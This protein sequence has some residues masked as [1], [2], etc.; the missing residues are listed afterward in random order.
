[1]RYDFDEVIQRKHT[2]SSKWDNVG[3]RV[4]NPD[5]LPLWVADTDFRCPQPVVD[6][7]IQRAQHPIYG[8]PYVTPDFYD[9]TVNWIEKRHGWRL[10]PEWI[11]FTTGIVPVF[12]TMIQA[13]TE[14]GDEVIVQRPVYHPI[15]H[16]IEDNGRAISINRL[17]YKNGRYSV[18]FE[19]LECRVKN[20]KAKLMLMCSPHNPAGGRVWTGTELRRIMEITLANDVLVVLDEIHSDLVLFGN[21]HIP[22]ASLDARYLQHTVTC[23]APSKT[24]NIAGLRG[25][26]IV[27]PNAE[28]RARFERQIK[29][30]RSVAQ[31]VFA[32][33]AYV[34]AYEHGEEYLAQLLP[35][36]EDNY[37][38]LDSYLKENMPRIKLVWPESTFLAWLDC[39][40]TGLSGNDLADFFIH[41]SLVAISRGDSFGPE[42]GDF[43]RI[44]VGCPRATLKKA[45]DNV[46]AEYD[47]RW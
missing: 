15:N 35:Y 47:K 17:I 24:F 28:L 43:A 6:A 18:D 36:L 22:A 14:P 34:A 16:A 23:Y 21:R 41:E 7:V 13:F 11:V 10:K 25:S 19:D 42:G 26:G 37:R 46:K 5:A 44:N 12:S 20:P 33:P 8:Y 32:L 9:A 1:M 38:F 27:I 39:K 45:L 4:G 31:T 2:G 40:E 3:V 29:M 30:N